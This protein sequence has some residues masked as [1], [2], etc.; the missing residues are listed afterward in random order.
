[1]AE[2]MDFHVNDLRDKPLTTAQLLF[3]F[4]F[5]MHHP[6]KLKIEDTNELFEQ[7][8][9][10][11]NTDLILALRKLYDAGMESLV[12]GDAKNAKYALVL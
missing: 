12:D 6:N 1:M 4:A 2:R 8:G 10:V 5:Q 9:G 11:A 7:F 3:Y